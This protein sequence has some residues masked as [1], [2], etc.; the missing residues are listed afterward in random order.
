ME[1]IVLSIGFAKQIVQ[2]YNTL[3]RPCIIGHRDVGF[4]NFIL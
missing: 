4:T 1:G 3:S 2:T